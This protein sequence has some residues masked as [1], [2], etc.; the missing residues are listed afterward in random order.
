LEVTLLN[1]NAKKNSN[2]NF[3]LLFSTILA[4]VGSYMISLDFLKFGAASILCSIVLV[5]FSFLLP[6]ILAPLNR[7]WMQLSIF[8]GMIISP[9]VLAC[10]F[11]LIFT[12]ISLVSK[13]FGRD[14]LCLSR[15]D[16]STLWAPKYLNNEKP[17]SFTQQF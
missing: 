4:V 2:R 6:D 7:V 9:L 12:P 13:V 15:G 11:F 3:G 16:R 8:L 1:L 17:S 14:E 5:F 10:L